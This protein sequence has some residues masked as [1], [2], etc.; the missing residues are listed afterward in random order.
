LIA[1]NKR[2][3]ELEQNQALQ[4]ALML[5]GFGFATRWIS[6]WYLRK[7]TPFVNSC[8]ESLRDFSYLENVS[9]KDFNQVIK[10]LRAF[11]KQVPAFDPNSNEHWLHFLKFLKQSCQVEIL[12]HLKQMGACPPDLSLDVFEKVDA[13]VSTHGKGENALLWLAAKAINQY[14]ISLPKELGPKHPHKE[15]IEIAR[16]YARPSLRLLP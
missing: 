7:K 12:S 15:P 2:I 16:R 14:G 4:Q 8:F 6:S 3:T 10:S 1:E 11:L 9:R 5:L 13:N